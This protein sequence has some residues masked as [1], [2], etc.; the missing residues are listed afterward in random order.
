MLFPAPQ[1]TLKKPS[2]TRGIGETRHLTAV[3]VTLVANEHDDLSRLTIWCPFG[4]NKWAGDWAQSHRHHHLP[5]V[6]TG[7]GPQD[8]VQL[9]NKWLKMVDITIVHGG[10]N[11][12]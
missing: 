5:I 4:Q 6:T 8:S 3:Q 7:W 2:R 11:G 9:P 10:Y 1:E 12:L